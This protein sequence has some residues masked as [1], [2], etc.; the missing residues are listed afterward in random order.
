MELT[1]DYVQEYR[2]TGG[3]DII[4]SGRTK[5]ET[6][7]QFEKALAICKKLGISAIMIIGGDDSNT[8]A[9]L[10]AE[11]H[12]GKGE[13]IQLSAFKTIDGD[14]KNE[15]FETSFGFDTATKVYSELYRKHQRDANSAK[16]T[17]L[18]N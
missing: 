6:P 3:F 10:L 1:A 11:I 9:A 7:E 16:N 18:L 15:Q 2:N 5:L 17:A 13:D 8:N 4:G 12:E 14:L